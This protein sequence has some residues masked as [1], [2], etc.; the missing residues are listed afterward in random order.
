MSTV[1]AVIAVS[2]AQ[3]LPMTNQPWKDVRNVIE[4]MS[5]AQLKLAFDLA[6]GL[7][8]KDC[9]IIEKQM[10]RFATLAAVNGPVE[11]SGRISHSKDSS[12][13]DFVS[14]TQKI[15]SANP[16]LWR[17]KASYEAQRVGDASCLTVTKTDSVT[18]NTVIIVFS[19]KPT[20][21]PVHGYGGVDT[22]AWRPEV[23]VVK[24]ALHR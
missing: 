4:T 5:P 12:L 9:N 16:A 8:A 24:S 2:L 19:D 22:D 17:G 11:I 10:A 20:T 13:S 15:R 18:G 6:D 7:N 1:A 3:M 21:V 23:I 14:D